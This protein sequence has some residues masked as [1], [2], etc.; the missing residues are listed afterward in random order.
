[1]DK[2]EFALFIAKLS[3]LGAKF[4][5]DDV[6]EINVILARNSAVVNKGAIAHMVKCLYTGK[7][8]DAIK[9]Y[10]ELTG[11]T[12]KEALELMPTTIDYKAPSD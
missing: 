3:E 9:T 5:E 12:L 2:I 11:S 8:I 10:R 4:T 1:M 7:R 6:K